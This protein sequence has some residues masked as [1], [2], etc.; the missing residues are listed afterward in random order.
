M[1]PAGAYR[2]TCAADAPFALVHSLDQQGKGTL[3]K[4]QVDSNRQAAWMFL[5]TTELVKV[6]RV[7]ATEQLYF[8]AAYPFC[9]KNMCMTQ[10]LS[11]LPVKR[12]TYHAQHL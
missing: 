8:A 7:H 5:C 11:I 3:R 12:A 1:P 4:R 6:R 2:V 9:K 10:L